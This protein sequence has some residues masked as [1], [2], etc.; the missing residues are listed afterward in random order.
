M[1]KLTKAQKR[2]AAQ[3]A[4]WDLLGGDD[5]SESTRVPPAGESVP[6]RRGVGAGVRHGDK[7]VPKP[8]RT[9]DKGARASVPARVIPPGQASF[10]RPDEPGPEP[11]DSGVDVAR[12]IA[13]GLIP[14][15]WQPGDLK[16]GDAVWYR[17]DRFFIE[18]APS[19][20]NFTDGTHA[21]ICSKP[22]RA[23]PFPLPSDNPTKDLLTFC[24]HLDTLSKAP[25]V[26]AVAIATGGLTGM[27]SLKAVERKERLKQ[28]IK[29]VGDPVALALRDAKALDDVYRIG[30]KAL[31]EKVEFLKQKF[32][33]LNNGQQRMQVGNRMRNAAKKGKLRL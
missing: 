9:A 31:G 3:K 17:S 22:V 29:D 19:K 15:K 14:K 25:P 30:A 2:A 1:T 12:L 13:P 6:E 28:G 24:V 7:P 33:H 27:D 32:G 26:S 10:E 4:A 11:A 8:K 23:A 21:R 20:P 18:W 5:A 16:R